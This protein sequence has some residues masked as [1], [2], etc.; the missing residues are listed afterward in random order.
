MAD[1]E[2]SSERRA[3]PGYRDWRTGL[4]GIAIVLVLAAVF[5]NVPDYGPHIAVAAGV[6]FLVW[7]FATAKR[8]G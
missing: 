8:R 5:I 3:R 7:R 4:V 1:G 6:G 2:K